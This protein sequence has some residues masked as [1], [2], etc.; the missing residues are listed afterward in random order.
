VV[1]NLLLKELLCSP[2][3]LRSIDGLAGLPPSSGPLLAPSKTA[4]ISLDIPDNVET[5]RK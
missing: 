1:K 3:A 4:N 5:R 2:I